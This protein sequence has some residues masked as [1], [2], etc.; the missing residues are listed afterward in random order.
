MRRVGSIAIVHETLSQT[1]RTSGR[2]RRDRRPGRRDG[3]G[4]VGTGGSGSRSGA[5]GSFGVL[6]PEVATPLAMVLTELLQNA[7]EHGLAG[8]DG[9]GARSSVAA[10]RARTG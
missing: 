10:R 3:R 5:T 6:P 9:D 1:P 8:R 7:L 4:G 2:L